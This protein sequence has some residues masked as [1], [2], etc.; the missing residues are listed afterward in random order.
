MHTP[1]KRSNPRD[2]L[3]TT[4][5]SELRGME[6]GWDFAGITCGRVAELGAIFQKYYKIPGMADV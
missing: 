3:L 1:Q 4:G 5:K 2:S 6:N